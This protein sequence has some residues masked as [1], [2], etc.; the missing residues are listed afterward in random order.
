[1]VGLLGAAAVLLA[2]SGLG[3]LRRPGRARVAV[4]A[5]GV[6]MSRWLAT[7]TAVRAAGA[8]ELLGATLVLVHGGRAAA[9]ATALV[10]AG[11]TAVAVV[12]LRR[13]PGQD[14]GCFGGA[15]GAVS[16]WHVLSNAAFTA[17]GAAGL[18]AP[19]TS[20]LAELGRQPLAGVPFAALV[21]TLAAGCYLLMTALPQL[22]TAARTAR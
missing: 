14:C 6:P 12:L 20:V 3:K 5:A 7:V 21:A 4:A 15:R 17:A 16:R 13:A 19:P 9:G 1:M 22:S 2:V 8:V 18:A 10:F 11:L